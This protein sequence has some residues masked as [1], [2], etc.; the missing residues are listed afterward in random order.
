MMLFLEVLGCLDTVQIV[1]FT[2]C[3]HNIQSYLY[4]LA[5]SVLSRTAL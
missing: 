1:F 3:R 4:V 5:Y 2:A